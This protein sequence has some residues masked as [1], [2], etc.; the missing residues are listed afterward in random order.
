MAI[1]FF[2]SNDEYVHACAM[3]VYS[4]SLAKYIYN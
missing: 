3:N 1:I 2:G 4:Y